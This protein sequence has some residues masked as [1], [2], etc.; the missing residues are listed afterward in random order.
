MP[1]ESG[2]RI[3]QN[4]PYIGKMTMTSQI[5]GMTY[6]QFFWHCYVSP[7]NCSYWPKFH[8]NIITGSGVMTILVYKRIDQEFENRK[9]PPSEFSPI[10]GCCGELWILNLTPMSLVESY[11]V[12]PN[13]RVTTL[14]FLSYLGKVNRVE[15]PLHPD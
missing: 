10:S 14:L 6:R 4:W 3:A 12:L 7:V 1:L 2:F 9:Y 11:I 5:V 8:V 15:Y 13:I